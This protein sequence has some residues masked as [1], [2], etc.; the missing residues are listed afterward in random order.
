M[1]EVSI[2]KPEDNNNLWGV[3][4]KPGIGTTGLG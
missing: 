2:T 4:R 1:S 3:P